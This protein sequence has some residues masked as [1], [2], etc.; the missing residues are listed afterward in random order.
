MG[1]YG[2]GIERIVACY[3]EQHHDKDGIVWNT[4]LAPYAVQVTAVNMNSENTVSHAEKIYE[5]FSA[6][7]IETMF[8]DRSDVS[9]G[10]K[11]K[12]ADLLGMP[13]HVIVGDKNLKNNQVE[14]KKRRTGERIL[15]GFEE[16]LP[17]IQKLLR[18]NEQ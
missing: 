8:D 15:V 9:P 6:A 18:N 14:I 17:E 3:I 13:F 16:I 10:F 12:D 5:L 4:A 7:G 11:F 1:S 2:I